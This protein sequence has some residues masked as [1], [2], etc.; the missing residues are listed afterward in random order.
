MYGNPEDNLLFVYLYMHCDDRLKTM[1]SANRS[2][3]P[4]LCGS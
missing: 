1:V 3:L 2:I 4:D